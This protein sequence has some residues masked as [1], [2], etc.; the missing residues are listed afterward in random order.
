MPPGRNRDTVRVI[1]TTEEAGRHFLKTQTRKRTTMGIFAGMQGATRGFASNKLTEGDYV[2]RVDKCDLFKTDISGNCFKITLTILAV[3]DGPHKAGE[4]VTVNFGDKRITEKQ[5][6]GNIK[7]FI[8]GVMNVEDSKVGEAETMRTLDPSQDGQAVMNGT[9]CRVKAFQRASKSAR[10]KNGEPF[11]YSVY[12]WSPSLT[13]EEIL[14]IIG[15]EGIK[16]FFPNG[17]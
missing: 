15:E 17:L 2:A 4:V 10:D 8:A 5:W 7:S 3:S 9:V 1:R 13:D 12:T 11:D 6:L 14:Q 16:R